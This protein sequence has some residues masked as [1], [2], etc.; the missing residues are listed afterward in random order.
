L[1]DFGEGRIVRPPPDEIL[2]LTERPYLP[3]GTLRQ[4]LVPS[5]REQDPGDARIEAVL[6]GLGV[7][8]VLAKAGGLDAERDWNEVL[9]LGEQQLLSFARL[10]LATPSYAVLDRPETVLGVESVV[11]ALDF[12]A[13]EGITVVTFSGEPALADRHDA[14][15]VLAADGS[16]N[17]EA[18]QL[19]TSTGE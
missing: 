18:R 12:L 11:R 8:G 14:H 15:L 10:A 13:G 6:S 4:A 3:P 9:S 2:L 17:F 1:W 7:G 19:A 16:W 5:G